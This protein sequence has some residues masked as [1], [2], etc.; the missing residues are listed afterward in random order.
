MSDSSDG[1]SFDIPK[2]WF[3][4]VHQNIDYDEK[5]IDDNYAITKPQ[6]AM[7]VGLFEGNTFNSH[8]DLE[9]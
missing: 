4:D 1:R 8:S 7:E 5:E 3:E 9:A 6:T 2:K